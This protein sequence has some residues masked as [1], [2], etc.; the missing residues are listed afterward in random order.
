MLRFR[1]FGAAEA[2]QDDAAVVVRGGE[3]VVEAQGAAMRRF[4]RRPG[5]HSF[6]R[7]AEVGQRR[8]V[9]G[10]QGQRPA[11]GRG[12]GRAVP[13]RQPHQPQR[14]VCRRVHRFPPQR[15]QR[16]LGCETMVAALVRRQPRQVKRH[17]MSG[18]APKDLFVKS[19]GLGG[20]PL[21]VQRSGLLQ[22]GVRPVLLAHNAQTAQRGRHP[23]RNVGQGLS[24]QRNE[25]LHR[26]VPRPHG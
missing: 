2:E 13:L 15:R 8:R 25:R 21:A 26:R 5:L 14:G 20:P 4:R 11:E 16:T 9:G 17:R 7:V 19:L 12:G 18:L 24:R 23:G 1:V 10:R 22:A 6:Q 3:A